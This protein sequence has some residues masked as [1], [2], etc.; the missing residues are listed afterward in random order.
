MNTRT[1]TRRA[2]LKVVAA[3]NHANKLD[4]A[5]VHALIYNRIP[6]NKAL[7]EKSRFLVGLMPLFKTGVPRFSIGALGMLNGAL[8][9]AFGG[10]FRIGVERAH[11]GAIL[12]FQLNKTAR[13]EQRR[14]KAKRPVAK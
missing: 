7:A 5:A 14:V 3:L 12:S 11:D 9:A 10:E 4:P 6:C 2:L 13:S 1:K 8:H